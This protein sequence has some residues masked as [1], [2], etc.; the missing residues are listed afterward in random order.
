MLRATARGRPDLLRHAAGRRQLAGTP[1]L[2]KHRFRR[3]PRS[4]PR[5]AVL[6]LAHARSRCYLGQ[7]LVSMSS[8]KKFEQFRETMARELDSRE[9]LAYLKEKRA[10]RLGIGLEKAGGGGG[11]CCGGT[12]ASAA[13][14]R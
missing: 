7:V 5:A 12:S 10:K 2:P 8:K 1:P 9:R 13:A 14:A 11:S 4:V 3:H 6:A